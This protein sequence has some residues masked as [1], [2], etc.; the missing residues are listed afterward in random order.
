MSWPLW[1]VTYDLG[2]HWHLLVITCLL[3]DQLPDRKNYRNTKWKKN[4]RQLIK[5]YWIKFRLGFPALDFQMDLKWPQ[6]PVLLRSDHTL[7]M[8]ATVSSY[9]VRMS[10]IG[11]FCMSCIAAVGSDWLT[12]NAVWLSTARVVCWRCNARSSQSANCPFFSCFHIT[13]YSSLMHSLAKEW[14]YRQDIEWG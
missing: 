11:A 3:A 9:A 1:P 7:S 14:R 8:R 12:V 6:F 10:E 5:L 2:W 13:S 4:C